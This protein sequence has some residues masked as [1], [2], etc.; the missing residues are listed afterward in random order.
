MQLYP[1]SALTKVHHEAVVSFHVVIVRISV[2]SQHLKKCGC[3]LNRNRICPGNKFGVLYIHI[4]A[5]IHIYGVMHLY[6]GWLCT[7]Y[8]R[9]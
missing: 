5:C 1:L 4:G 2:L 7:S 3:S 6:T 8:T 9:T